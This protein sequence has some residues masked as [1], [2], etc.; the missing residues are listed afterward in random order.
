MV[1]GAVRAGLAVGV[2]MALPV[3]PSLAIRWPTARACKAAIVNRYWI[4]RH[5]VT[6]ME[7]DRISHRRGPWAVGRGV[8]VLI[9]ILCGI[10]TESERLSMKTSSKS[11]T[12]TLK[13]MTTVHKQAI[14]RTKGVP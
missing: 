6:T 2:L 10:C 12:K 7:T 3:N 1:H 4:F 9:G 8:D 11:A 13:R 5:V 14:D